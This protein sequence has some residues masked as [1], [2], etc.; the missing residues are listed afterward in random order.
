M[1]K[2]ELF[3]DKLVA[4]TAEASRV[5]SWWPRHSILVDSHLDLLE[6]DSRRGE[7]ESFVVRCGQEW[8]ILM[9]DGG[10]LMAEHSSLELSMIE[11][12][13]TSDCAAIDRI[14]EA[15]EQNIRKQQAWQI[16]K[17]KDFPNRTF[18]SLMKDHV[19]L[20]LESVVHKMDGDRRKLL[21]CQAK[22]GH[23]AVSM[24]TLMTEWV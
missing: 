12:A 24:G 1:K 20:F 23:N 2:R 22:R 19:R 7:R 3:A 15:L 21:L 4:G 17:S 6:D 14:Q 10:G 18:V 9:G 5:A 11:A 16:S 13:A 8:D